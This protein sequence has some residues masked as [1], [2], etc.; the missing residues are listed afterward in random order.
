VI[1]VYNKQKQVSIPEQKIK[2]S[3]DNSRLNL[4]VQN[5][6]ISQVLKSPLD[7]KNQLK[8]GGCFKSP[9]KQIIPVNNNIPIKNQRCISGINLNNKN[10]KKTIENLITQ[11]LVDKCTP[12]M[13][14]N[15]QSYNLLPN[16]SKLQI[17]ENENKAYV[18]NRPITRRVNISTGSSQL[19]ILKSEPK[20]NSNYISSQNN[21]KRTPTSISNMGN[22]KNLVKN[23]N[24]KQIKSNNSKGSF[25][26]NNDSKS[27]VIINNTNSDFKYITENDFNN[28]M[29]TPDKD[30]FNSLFISV[31]DYSNKINSQN[32]EKIRNGVNT[33]EKDS[34]NKINDT[35]LNSILN[36]DVKS[37]NISNAPM[38]KSKSNFIISKVVS[39]DGRIIDMSNVQN[40][41]REDKPQINS[42][43][44][45]ISNLNGKSVEILESSFEE[46]KIDSSFSIEKNDNNKFLNDSFEQIDDNED[47]KVT[48]LSNKKSKNNEIKNTK[49]KQ[50]ENL[51]EL[52]KDKNK[53]ISKINEYKEALSNL[54]GKNIS[55]QL[56]QEGHHVNESN[57]NYE[58]YIRSISDYAEKYCPENLEKV[59]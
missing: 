11:N 17:N 13:I 22:Y 20:N 41:K 2:I 18:K 47:E 23:F 37:T 27:S 3:I 31:Q 40:N 45:E 6:K 38:I 51:D 14:K 10:N 34:F 53:F 58:E 39:S 8:S 32:K 55:E 12:M 49:L 24:D 26:F 16:K 57:K 54:I 5:S 4:N 7:N 28:K 25:V 29:H 21:F 19:E 56:L 50:D 35:D 36:S 52:I 48:I 59:R 30:I 33:K 44:Q 9:V 15:K 1:S 42:P 46:N 43:S